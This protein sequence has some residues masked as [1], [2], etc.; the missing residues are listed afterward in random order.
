MLLLHSKKD[1][2]GELQHGHKVLVLMEYLTMR[3]LY[4]GLL[5]KGDIAKV[6]K[7]HVCVGFEIQTIVSARWACRVERKA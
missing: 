7:T 3:A 1:Y 6:V 4:H 5:S 2:S